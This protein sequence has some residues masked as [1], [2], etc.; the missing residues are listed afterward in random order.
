MQHFGVV[1]CKI[2]DESLIF[3]RYNKKIQAV[4]EIFNG[5]PREGVA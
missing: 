5:I 2:S 4:R 1:Y 3:S